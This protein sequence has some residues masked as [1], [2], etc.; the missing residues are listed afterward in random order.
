MY[1]N[2]EIKISRIANGWLVMLPMKHNIEIDQYRA[3]GEGM[4]EGF[5][6]DPLL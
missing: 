5:K 4:L 6:T 3:M 1:G 2:S